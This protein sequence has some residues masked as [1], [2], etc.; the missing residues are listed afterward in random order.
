M[1]SFQNKKLLPA[2]RADYI[3]AT[4]MI[5]MVKKYQSCKIANIKEALRSEIFFNNIRLIRKSA[6]RYAN[7]SNIDVEDLFNSG[8]VGFF[9]GLDRFNAYKNVKFS[10]YIRFWIDKEI[11]EFLREKNIV[12]IPRGDFYRKKDEVGRALNNSLVYLDR[13]LDPSDDMSPKLHELIKDKKAAN[14]EEDCIEVEELERLDNA[15]NTCLDSRE[16]L[17][18]KTKFFN[19]KSIRSESRQGGY[20]D[21]TGSYVLKKALLKLKN[22]L[23]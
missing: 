10:T 22:A 13:P 5:A 20:S 15:I 12:H 16:R 18:I 2:L 1:S 3:S 11:Y 7:V 9:D 14:A 6:M 8:V 21:S 19:N 4:D 23:G 17:L